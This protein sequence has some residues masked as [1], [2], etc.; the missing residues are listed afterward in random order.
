MHL[1]LTDRKEPRT[2][3]REE[4]A[5]VSLPIGEKTLRL[6]PLAGKIERSEKEKRTAGCSRVYD[7]KEKKDPI[8]R[9]RERK[10]ETDYSGPSSHYAPGRGEGGEGGWFIAAINY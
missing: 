1:F 5:T 3:K 4:T 10:E 2:K 9:E 7:Q 6:H 8:L